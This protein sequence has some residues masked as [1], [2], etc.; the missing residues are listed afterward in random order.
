MIR[1]F[2]KSDFERR[3]LMLFFFFTF[4]VVLILTLF[5]WQLAKYGIN[6]YEDIEINN[7]MID[8]NIAFEDLVLKS[9]NTLNE[10]TR[11]E[12]I[13]I[14]SAQKNQDIIKE[15]IIEKDMESLVIFDRDRNIWFG[16]NW[17][18]LQKYLP[19]IYQNASQTFFDSFVGSYDDKLYLI[20]FSP[21]I[22]P[23][24][25]SEL[26]GIF[27]IS[28]KL[29]IQD[30]KIE[31]LQNLA[32][33]SCSDIE[34]T[35]FRFLESYADKLRKMISDFNKTND[36]I[37]HRLSIS[38]SVFMKCFF[39]LQKNPTGLFIISYHRHV[40]SF[41]QQSILI[42]LLILLASTLVV[43]SFLGNWFRKTILRPVQDVSEK[44]NEIAMKPSEFHK[45]D[46]IYDGVLGD[47]ANSFNIMNVALEN[48]S[49]NLRDYKLITDNIETGIFWL[50]NNFK[51]LLC[52]LGF[53][54]IVEIEDLNSI[55][56]VNIS[57]LLGLENNLKEKLTQGSITIPAQEITIHSFKKFV[58][59]NIRADKSIKSVRFFGSITD[60]T[61]EINAITAVEALEIELIKSNKLAEIGSKI[62]GIVHNLNSPLNSILGYAQ[63]YKKGNRDLED[64]DKIIEAGRNAARI[65]KGLLDKVKQSNTGMIRPININD[66]VQQELNLCEHNLFF[67]HYVILEKDL[68]PNIP[69]ITAIYGDISLCIANLLNNA[70]DAMQDSVDKNLFVKTYADENFVYLDVEDSGCGI[71]KA[72]FENIFQSYY[73]TK[74]NNKASGF[75][76][77]LAISKNVMEKYNGKIEVKSIVGKGTTFTIKLPINNQEKDKI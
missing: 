18:L 23:G 29:D 20:T 64:I 21:C 36:K 59:L 13:I 27:I 74:T 47:M 17:E 39:D 12:N 72:E 14:A 62:E 65:V 54:Q 37:Y 55:I 30:F 35:Q 10:I 56:N 45:L 51:V 5:A 3:V 8:F 57:K 70:F 28:K 34:N 6:Q 19:Q 15:A 76:L 31:S 69:D 22:S 66:V 63:L 4:L 7:I 40:N 16:E 26:L 49:K 68:N 38:Q 52:N 48:H 43:V 41:A 77:G 60:I 2:K 1:I 61:K 58:I 53:Q 46:N 71:P 75:G 33:V 9:Q 50:D 24:P 25:N 11:D 73:S 42:F 44:M 32:L 67:K